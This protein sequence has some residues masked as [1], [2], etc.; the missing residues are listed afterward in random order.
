MFLNDPGMPSLVVA[1]QRMPKKWYFL[2]I[3][4]KIDQSYF[5]QKFLMMHS[6]ALEKL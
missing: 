2:R 6:E 1:P 4:V 3:F 5:F